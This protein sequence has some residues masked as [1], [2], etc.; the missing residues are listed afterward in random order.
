MWD[1]DQSASS[2][3][4]R[5]KGDIIQLISSEKMENNHNKNNKN[6]QLAKA[7]AKIQA[8]ARAATKRKHEATTD[9]SNK[10]PN[11]NNNNS[12]NNSNNVRKCDHC[13]KLGHTVEQCWKKHPCEICGR[14]N[15]STENCYRKPSQEE[16]NTE[17]SNLSDMFN[18]SH[19]D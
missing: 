13:G 15:H 1:T 9:D 2:T 16:G 11:N 14:N 17:A 7:Q 19:S 10:K 18:A 6:V 3:Y 8:K 12:S 4:E 5:L